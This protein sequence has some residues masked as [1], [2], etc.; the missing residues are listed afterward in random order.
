MGGH[1]P[2]DPPGE[3]RRQQADDRWAG[4][5]ERGDVHP[6][7][8]L[9]M[10]GAAEGPAAAEHGGRL[11]AALGRGPHARSHPPR[12]LRA[13][14]RTGRARGQPDGGDHRR[15]ERQRRGKGGRRIDPSGY[16]AGKKI[17]G[18]KRHVLVDT[19]GLL[20]QAIIHAADIQDRDGGLLLMGALFGLYPFLLRA[21]LSECASAP[22]FPSESRSKHRIR[23]A[24]RG[25]GRMWTQEHRAR[26]AA[27]VKEMVSLAGIG[28]VARWLERAD[29]PRKGARRTPLRAV[30][31]GLVWHLRTGGAWRALPRGFP[32]WRTVYGWLRRWLDM[33]ALDALLRGAARLRRRAASR[34]RPPRLAVID[35]QSVECI[36][37]RG[38][39]GY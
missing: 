34:P 19:Q 5:G 38:P 20:M 2:A 29:P 37:V 25:E 27:G 26:H 28:E 4:G 39:R 21:C 36:P 9:P 14:P 10:G 11:P 16:D 12:A 31:S 30:V 8:R 23:L 32:P 7:H 22:A 3:A 15:P 18:R 17:K 13:V 35:T 33:G 6:L 1:R 24:G